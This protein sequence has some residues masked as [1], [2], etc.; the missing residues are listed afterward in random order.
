MLRYIAAPALAIVY[1]FSYGAFYEL[2]NDP[3]HVM[4]FGVGH[5]ALLLIAIGFIVPKWYDTF[6]PPERRGEGKT[7]YGV[8]VPADA[9]VTANISDIESSG[10]RVI[11]DEKKADDSSDLAK[12]SS[13]DAG[14]A[15]IG[16]MEKRNQKDD[17]IA[18]TQ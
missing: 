5:I 14:A 6:I 3:L 13:P 7:I 11:D 2:R 18:A 8:N 15:P 9:E 10:E 4:G 17:A 1:S 12:S 16:N